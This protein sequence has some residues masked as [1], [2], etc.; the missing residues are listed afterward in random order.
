MPPQFEE[1]LFLSVRLYVRLSPCPA[2]V[3]QA[4]A[5]MSFRNIFFLFYTYDFGKKEQKKID[6]D[7]VRKE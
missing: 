6:C 1:V 2:L 3:F 7:I 4:A 5:F